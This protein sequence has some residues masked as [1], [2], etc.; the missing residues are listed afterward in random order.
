M[1]TINEIR[2]LNDRQ[3]DEIRDTLKPRI[4]DYVYSIGWAENPHKNFSCP[5][6]GAGTR[7]PNTSINPNT[8]RIKGW[9]C[10]CLD[11]ADLFKLIEINE[12]TVNNTFEALA[13]ACNLFG[14]SLSAGTLAG[15]V[16][17]TVQPRRYMTQPE[18]EQP[19][20]PSREW[21][22]EAKDFVRGCESKLWQPVGAKARSY[23]IEKRKLTEKTLRHFHV[24]YNPRSY[25]YDGEWKAPAGIVIPTFI[26]EDL[27][28]VKVR[29]DDENP[30]YQNY[31]GS[32]NCCPFNEYDLLHE[33]DVV[34]VEGEIDVM[35]IYQAGNCGAVSFGSMTAIPSAVTWRE[36]LKN[37]DR[38][39]I[40]L[41]ADVHGE[42][43]AKKMLAEIKRLEN[44]R[45]VDEDAVYIRQLP[46]P[47]GVDKVDWN[48]LYT[49]GSDIVETLDT[50]FPL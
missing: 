43:G 1:V 49:A 23:L 12:P 33:V 11:G 15:S 25:F 44:I 27:Y 37:P 22:R 47:A 8:Y 48:G 13:F 2:N 36:W 38:I 17:P 26:G 41:D 20:P 50:F 32:V 6:C 28:R 30:K 18:Q 42:D 31:K 29:R 16:T 4:Y 5:I 40:C 21:Q 24:G 9:S 35:T 46:K 45:P 7:T 19:V 34:I 14:Y 10:H 39:C 3:R